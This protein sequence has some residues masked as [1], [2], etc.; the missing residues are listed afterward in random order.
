M[1]HCPSTCSVH[2]QLS[3]NLACG[4]TQTCL[5]VSVEHVNVHEVLQVFGQCVPSQACE[6]VSALDALG[7][8]VCPV[9]LVLVY[10]EAKGVRQLAANQNLDTKP[11]V[12]VW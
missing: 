4:L 10:S 6:L 8:P 1:C 5:A 12:E 2:V 9:Q 7:L 3:H 11:V